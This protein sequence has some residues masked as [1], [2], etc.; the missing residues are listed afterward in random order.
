M[1]PHAALSTAQG[2][3]RLA[4][5]AFMIQ[6]APADEVTIRVRANLGATI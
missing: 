1:L 3:I 6:A 5:V 4:T 2:D